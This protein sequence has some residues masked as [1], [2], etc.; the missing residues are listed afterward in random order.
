ML[1]WMLPGVT[2]VWGGSV[3]FPGG[4]R[5]DRHRAGTS[6]PARCHFQPGTLDLTGHRMN[7]LPPRRWGGLGGG[8]ESHQLRAEAACGKL[9]LPLLSL[10]LSCGRGVGTLH[11]HKVHLR[12]N[13]PAVSEAFGRAGLGSLVFPRS[14][15]VR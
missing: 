4:H 15:S 2:D 1:D 11:Q 3:N 7:S 8:E 10:S 6:C 5:S 13:T 12:V 14:C 9:M